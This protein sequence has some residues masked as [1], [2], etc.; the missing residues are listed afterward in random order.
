MKTISLLLL[1][2]GAI[3]LGGCS[4]EPSQGT[5]YVESVR[6]RFNDSGCNIYVGE[7]D[8]HSYLV[9]SRGGI[10]HNENCKCRTQKVTN[11]DSTNNETLN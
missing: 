8:G 2:I 6:Y 11:K 7:I 4:T 10:T 5:K 9:H 1:A 3:I